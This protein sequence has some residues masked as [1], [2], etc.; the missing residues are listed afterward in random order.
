MRLVIESEKISW[1]VTETVKVR[2]LVINDSY[3]TV[4]VDRRLLIGPNPVSEAGDGIPHPVSREPAF[5]SDQENLVLLN[6]WGV[7]G[8]ERS[9]GNLPQGVTQFHAYLLSSL[10]D[11]LLPERP[12]E[13]GMAQLTATPI[14]VEI[15]G[16]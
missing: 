4:A 15:R 6:P 9:F 1:S 11:A 5:A 2:V 13:P 12:A 16:E 10:T 7:F 3:E 14:P 8:R